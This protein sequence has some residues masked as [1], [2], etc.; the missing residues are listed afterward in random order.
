[1]LKQAERNKATYQGRLNPSLLEVQRADEEPVFKKVVG[2]ADLDVMN[3]NA[4]KRRGG[5][6]IL[7]DGGDVAWLLKTIDDTALENYKN[8]LREDI[9]TGANV[10]HMC[11]ESFGG[12]LSGVAISYKLWGLEQTWIY[13]NV[14][15]S[16]SPPE[17]PLPYILYNHRCCFQYTYHSRGQW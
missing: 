13:F 7:E 12:N 9:H 15:I 5:A 11:D 3:K 16:R 1:M 14:K 2:G 17:S 4:A 10:P 8:R 6:I